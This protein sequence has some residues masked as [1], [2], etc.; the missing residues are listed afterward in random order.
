MKIRATINKHLNLHVNR[1]GFI[2]H[3]WSSHGYHLVSTEEYESLVVVIETDNTSKRN[4][5][6]KQYLS[7]ITVYAIG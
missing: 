6:Y 3:P 1:L 7:I 2:A 5:V 4:V